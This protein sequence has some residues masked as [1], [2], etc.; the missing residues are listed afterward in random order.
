M[1][2][3]PKLKSSLPDLIFKI[4]LSEM[5]ESDVTG[6]TY[7]QQEYCCH[8]NSIVGHFFPHGLS[9]SLQRCKD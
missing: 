6:N 4:T 3:S 8:D 7:N 1:I 5:L 9:R 2:Q